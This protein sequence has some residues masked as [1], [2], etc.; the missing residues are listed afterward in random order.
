MLAGAS[1]DG[2]AGAS[3]DT[4]YDV[5]YM[6]VCTKNTSKMLIN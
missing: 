2:V 3:Y 1:Y 5:V 4:G 6:P